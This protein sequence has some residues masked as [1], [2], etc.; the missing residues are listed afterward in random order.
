[1]FGPPIVWSAILAKLAR[2]RMRHVLPFFATQAAT[3]ILL[4]EAIN[5]IEHYGLARAT[6]PD[7]SYEPVNPTHSWNSAHWVTNSMLFK[8]QRH[9]D[10]HTFPQRPYQLLRNFEESPQMPSGYLGMVALA[11]FPPAF[12]RIM[13]PLVDGYNSG[14]SD[15]KELEARAGARF[16]VWSCALFC[17]VAAAQQAAQYASVR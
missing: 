9:S 8:L 4:L 10:H 1:M 12:F 17:G 16:G 3:A 11:C 6:L 13:D 2:R 14:E 7:G 15:V 5:Y